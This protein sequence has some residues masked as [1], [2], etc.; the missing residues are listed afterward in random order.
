MRFGGRRN[1]AETEPLASHRGRSLLGKGDVLV[2]AEIPGRSRGA[3]S[4]ACF[5][6]GGLLRSEGSSM[7]L[8]SHDPC[9]ISLL[10]EQ[11]CH[12]MV[13]RV[14]GSGRGVTLGV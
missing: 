1:F 2:V 8:R 4:G 10:T 11:T 12:D 6:H 14:P 9:G 5:G 13:T 3:G 7:H